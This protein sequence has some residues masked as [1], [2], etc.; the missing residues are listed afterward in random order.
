MAQI[1]QNTTATIFLIT[2][3]LLVGTLIARK[4]AK[5]LEAAVT[6]ARIVDGRESGR[7]GSVAF[8]SASLAHIL[9]TLILAVVGLG[10][11]PNVLADLL[12]GL[13]KARVGYAPL[14]VSGLASSFPLAAGAVY[15]WCW[16]RRYRAEHTAYCPECRRLNERPHFPGHH[17]YPVIFTYAAILDGDRHL[18]RWCQAPLTFPRHSS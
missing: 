7:A 4:G 15:R 9:G 16:R 6:L 8:K 13:E 12:F 5:Q 3:G 2:W 17:Q 18:C 11:L 14:Q 10:L 1:L